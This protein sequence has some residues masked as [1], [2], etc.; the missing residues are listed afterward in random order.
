MG[1]SQ[2]NVHRAPLNNNFQGLE[3]NVRGPKYPKFE[4][5]ILAALQSFT[6]VAESDLMNFEQVRFRQLP[7]IQYLPPTKSNASSLLGWPENEEAETSRQ[8]TA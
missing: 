2:V 8:A 6:A 5:L 4:Q 1:P 7:L 3:K